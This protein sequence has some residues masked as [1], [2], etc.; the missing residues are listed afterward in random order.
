M[1]QFLRALVAGLSM[2]ASLAAAV[3]P[4]NAE[5][6]Q[7]CGQAEDAAHC[8]RLVEE[9]QMQR[10][11]NLARREG[12]MLSISLFPSGSA[13]F[14]DSEDVINGRSYSL[15]DYLDGINAVLLYT[16][17][18]DNV[19]FTLIQRSTNRR[20]E[21]PTEPH[22]SPDRRRLATA[23]ICE[24]RCTNEIAIWRVS[25]DGIRKELAWSAD[26]SWVDAGAKWKDT[27]TLTIDYTRT[28]G[29]G[30]LERTLTD[31]T[32]KRLQ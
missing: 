8:G 18:G 3:P 32:W 27:D 1:M 7:V 9:M 2:A 28:D 12:R 23:D 10:L 30:M 22:L 25:P 19:T 16:T 13:T 6:E 26:K 14:V 20:I 24:K 15:W 29:N 5:L 31:P 17:A 11:P 4:T 21:L